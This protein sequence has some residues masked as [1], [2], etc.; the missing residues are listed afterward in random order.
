MQELVEE[1]QTFAI[2][3]KTQNVSEFNLNLAESA[4]AQRQNEAS[5]KKLSQQQFITGE[6]YYQVYKNFDYWLKFNNQNSQEERNVK[7]LLC[8]PL[9]PHH[10]HNNIKLVSSPTFPS[11]PISSPF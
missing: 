2:D 3:F 7:L 5:I 6:P 10:L 4:L 1:E 9:I 8:L 11:F